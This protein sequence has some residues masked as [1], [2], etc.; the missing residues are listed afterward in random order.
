[1]LLRHYVMDDRFIVT[2]LEFVAMFVAMIV[3][4]LNQNS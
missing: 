4:N 2:Q 1:M 3:G